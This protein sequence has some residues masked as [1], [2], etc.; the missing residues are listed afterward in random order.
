MKRIQYYTYGGPEVM[1]LEDFELLTLAKGRITIKVKF[2]AINPIDWKV[3]QGNLKMLTGKSFPRAMGSDFSGT[4]LNVGTGV[5]RL[6]P[7]DPVFGLSRLKES[8]SLGEAVV[9]N[10]IFVAKKP[11][12]LSFEQ[13]ACLGT[14][15]VMAWMGLVD[16]AGLKAGQRD[17]VNGCTGS[18][19]E[20]VVQLAH[21]LGGHCHASFGLAISMTAR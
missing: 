19:G 21:M 9:T 10:E 14:A 1:H 2:A 6:K 16:K 4:V 15:G 5:T 8:G 17:F 13:A 12:E 11:S 3:R 7:G 20:T 18:V